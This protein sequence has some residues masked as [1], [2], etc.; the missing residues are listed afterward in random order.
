M[1]T[2]KTLL[3]EIDYFQPKPFDYF[4]EKGLNKKNNSETTIAI[5]IK[6]VFREDIVKFYCFNN[7]KSEIK[8]DIPFY[9]PKVPDGYAIFCSQLEYLQLMDYLKK[10][11]VEQ[12][13]NSEEEEYSL[14]AEPIPNKRHFICQICKTKFDNYKEHM[15]SKL[16]SQNKLKYKNTFGKIQSTFKRIVNFN[17]RNKYI[18]IDSEE[19]KINNA[20]NLKENKESKDNNNIITYINSDIDNNNSTT[21]EHSFLNNDENNANNRRKHKNDYIE[22]IDDDEEQKLDSFEDMDSIGI[23]NV[24]DSIQSKSK[25]RSSFLRKRRRKEKNIYLFNENYIYDLKKFTGIISS[26]NSLKKKI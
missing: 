13:Q 21:K 12:K 6:Q 9:H 19:N 5:L 3:E 2:I 18:N 7:S 17:K 26:F 10:K 20:I 11:N 23:L 14:E 22:L 25:K 8:N 24:L 1:I 16:H 4:I 15:D